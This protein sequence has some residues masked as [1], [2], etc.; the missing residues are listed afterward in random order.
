[1]PII[2]IPRPSLQFF[3]PLALAL[4]LTGCGEKEKDEPTEAPATP[5]DRVAGPA[6]PLY[7]DDGGT[8]G[9]PVVFVHGY[10]GDSEQWSA[11]LA[12]LRPTRRVV[13]S[14]SAVMGSPLR[15]PIM[16]MPS[17]PSRRISARSWTL[18]I[19]IGSSWWDTVWAA[20]RPSPTPRRIRTGWPAWSWSAHRA[21][22]RRTGPADHGADRSEVRLDHRRL[23]ATAS[24]RC[25]ARRPRTSH[26]PDAK[27]RSRRWPSSGRSC[28]STRCPC[29]HSTPAPSSRSS[30]LT[31]TG[32]TTYRTS[33]GG[34]PLAR[35]SRRV[36]GCTWTSRRSSTACWTRFCQRSSSLTRPVARA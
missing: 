23:L 20:P 6:G 34:C 32:R 12:H 11:Q 26:E 2:R 36:T 9:L 3:L 15:P 33:S 13:R 29:F 28:G 19:W 5:A 25:P 8:G 22:P 16:T 27:R 10:G 31:K 4:S 1:M 24:D 7:V 14:T 18:S 17:N 21:G 30:P 35:S